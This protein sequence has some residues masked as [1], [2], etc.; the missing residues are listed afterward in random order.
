MAKKLVIKTSR[1]KDFLALFSGLSKERLELLWAIRKHR[2]ESIYELVAITRKKQPYLQ[3]E[4]RFL[5]QKGLIRLRKYKENGRIK[6]KPELESQVL[7]FEL[8]MVHE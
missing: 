2:P 8:D 7:C 1:K 6:I 5:E 3:K 4:V